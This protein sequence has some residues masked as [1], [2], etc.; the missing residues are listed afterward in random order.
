M[1]CI[2]HNNYL[3]LRAGMPPFK[4]LA[5]ANQELFVPGSDFC[6]VCQQAQNEAFGHSALN[7]R[8]IRILAGID[9]RAAYSSNLRRHILQFLCEVWSFVSLFLNSTPQNVVTLYFGKADLMETRCH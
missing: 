7:A 2:D 9:T 4:R 6:Y 8:W 3:S 1:A 5:V